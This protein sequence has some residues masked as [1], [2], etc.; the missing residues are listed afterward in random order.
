MDEVFVAEFSG[1]EHAS[2]A[3]A[4]RAFVQQRRCAAPVPSPAP[5]SASAASAVGT[6]GL[7]ALLAFA[8]VNRPVHAVAVIRA[9]GVFGADTIS[10]GPPPADVP[11]P[12]ANRH[13][14]D[15]DP[16]ACVDLFHLHCHFDA[17][18]E[19]A[20]REL[21][22][23]TERTLAG[24]GTPAC[25]SYVWHERNGPH[26]GWS[27]ELWVDS[28]AA[29]GVGARHIMRERPRLVGGRLRCL[30]HCDSNQEYTDHA[31]RMAFIGPPDALDF[32]FF[33]PPDPARCA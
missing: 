6:A 28:I 3:A 11:V 16:D 24:A 33:K 26:I 7:G 12:V 23:S 27:W 15:A 4:A 19:E 18:T 31:A 20:A 5:S 22:A 9:P 29:L 8:Y 17:S 30:V 14:F 25:H 21:L 10:V 2:L 13:S 32:H 1:C